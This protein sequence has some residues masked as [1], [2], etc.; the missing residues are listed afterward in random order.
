[1][2]SK[3]WGRDPDWFSSLDSEMQTDLLANYR[4]ENQSKEESERKEKLVK[5]L[6]GSYRKERSAVGVK[7][8]ANQ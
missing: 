7:W 1:V 8:Q 6:N 2:I 5:K 3:S 4:I